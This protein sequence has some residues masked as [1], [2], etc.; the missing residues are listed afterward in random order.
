MTDLIWNEG[1]SVGIDAIDEDHKKIIAILSKLTSTHS[2]QIS[3][4]AI[5]NIF[6][7]LEQYVSLHFAREEALLEKVCYVNIIAHK[8]SHQKFIESL[9]VLKS[10]WLTEDNSACSERITTF[11]HKWIVNHIL[12]EDLDYVP[13]LSNS[14]NFAVQQLNSKADKFE[15]NSLLTKF[16]C[17][18]SNKIK[19]CQRVFITTFVPV[20]GVILL[21]LIVLQNSYQRYD[22]MSLVV[23]VNDVIMQVNNVSHSLQAERAIS[24][25]LTSDNYQTLTKQLAERRLITDQVIQQ[26]LTLINN[27]VA[28]AVRENI[29][30]HSEFARSNFNE[31]ATYRQHFDK[32]SANFKQTFQAYTAL[33]EQLLSISENLIHVEMSSTL[34]N[35]ISVISSVL[36]FKEYMGQ[37][38]ANGINT[39]TANNDELQS[40]L[41]INLLM[42]KQLNA[43]RVFD[44]LASN[45]QKKLCASSC[46][47]TWHERMLIKAFSDVNKLQTVEQRSKFWFDLMSGELD[48]LKVVT[49][50]LTSSFDKTVIAEN[51]RLQ[52]NFIIA[53]LVLS[54]F[55]LSAIFITS[56]LNLSI[57]N[58]IR[59]LTTAL[60]NM[61]K[62]DR[63]MQFRN[64]VIDDEIGAM[65]HAYEK[66]RRKL[67]QVDIFQAI[68]NSQKKEIEYRKTQQ[69]HFE[70]LAYTDALTGAVNR[71]QFNAA[72]AEEIARANYEGQPLSI[73]LLDIDFFKDVNDNFGHG[74]GDDVLV[75]FYKACK[76]A[77][78]SGDVVARI[79]GEEF[80]I[81]LPKS[82][83]QNAYHFAE[84]LREKIQQLSIMV[85]DKTVKLTVS[86]GVS[87][88]LNDL[89]SSA[90]E[91]VADADKSLYQAKEQGRNKVVANNL[92]A[93]L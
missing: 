48:K 69:E 29:R 28:T 60:N 37:I 16:S 32:T 73:L 71:Y 78:R 12:V 80:V 61:A 3:K 43:L 13:T 2:K 31:L 76:E 6:S 55:L 72:L 70:T 10:Q 27:D 56:I 20:V 22:N 17:S 87:E 19:L 86:I 93:T 92:R 68:V 33:I 74:V 39:I 9:P 75:M 11:L 8:A 45:H 50:S 35:D 24:S 14:S 65:Q 49:D 18:L 30:L 26:F 1:M 62:G 63:N 52:I 66:L 91:F 85:N 47:E 53:F 34:A 38:K 15:K 41:A 83:A 5:E 23:S 57:I 36:I 21:S 82:D 51:Q 7:E 64:T 4:L 58:P 77:A 88:W 25:N 84:R 46:D 42:G 67:L 81:I 40:N 90:E 89:F 59:R 79:G 44:N 54:V